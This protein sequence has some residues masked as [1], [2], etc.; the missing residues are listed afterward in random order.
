M[1]HGRT[2]VLEQSILLIVRHPDELVPVFVVLHS[3]D[4][5]DDIFKS[6]VSRL[7]ITLEA[8]AT[9]T[10]HLPGGT[11]A[12]TEPPT[13]ASE[14]LHTEAIKG[15]DDSYLLFSEGAGG[16]AHEISRRIHAVWQIQIPLGVSHVVV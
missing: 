10:L 4:K 9:G 11:S 15:S 13:I 6:Y 16:E 5:E 1:G 3:S 12:H 14:L 8:Y 2:L 7:V